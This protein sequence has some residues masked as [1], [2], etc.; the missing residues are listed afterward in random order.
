MIKS[1]KNN[2]DVVGRTHGSAPTDRYGVMGNPIQ[3]SLSP[4]IHALFA[5][6]THQ[7]LVYDPIL[8][9]LD[10]FS[11]ALLNFQEQGGK[12]VNITLPFKQQAFECVDVLSE[13]AKLARA[14]NTIK[15]EADG[16]RFGDNTD[17]IGFIRD[18]TMHH[19]FPL[20]NARILIL[21]AGGAAR[22]VLGAILQ[23]EPALLVIANRTAE[24][25]YALANEFSAQGL[26]SGCAL[27]QLTG[28]SFDLVINA[29]SASLQEEA[30]TLPD[31][32]LSEYAYCYDMVY[33]KG[34]TPFLTWAKEHG[35]AI[36]SDGLGML[37][38]QAAEAFL[39]WRN[40]KP[41]TASI[42]SARLLSS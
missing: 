16:V 20:K 27:S 19:A 41:D 7:Q 23:E 37:V 15:F 8:V 33:G 17:G 21:G 10:G 3:H 32:I 11:Q 28:Y 9:A 22:G 24:K 4:K 29:T 25:A 30:I 40:V 2:T 5:K 6:Q 36:T 35:A 18:V 38:E 34:Q 13:R 31:D 26:V 42:L 39:L 12:G 14:V 1:L